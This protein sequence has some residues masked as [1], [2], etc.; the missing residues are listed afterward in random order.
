[1]EQ[2]TLEQQAQAHNN[3]YTDLE[4]LYRYATGG[5]LVTDPYASVRQEVPITLT[6]SVVIPAWNAQG[7]LAQCLIAIEQSSFNRKYPGQLE[8]VVV[9][10]GSSDG[11]WAVLEHLE[12]GLRLKAVQQSHHS[13]AHTQ[14]TGIALAAG[15]V[16]ISC[17][18]DMILTPF[19]IEELMKRHQAL[20]DV[21]LLGFRSDIQLTD[22]RI[23]PRVLESYLPQFL[24]PYAQD[25][26]LN[27]AGGWPES[28]CR[29]TDHLKRLGHGKRIIMPDGSRWDL[30]GIVYGALFSL[31]RSDFL[32]MDGYDERFYGWGCEDT[33]VGVRALAMGKYI[34]PV[35]SAAGL[36][37]AHG[38]RSRRKWQEFAANT[39]VFHMIRHTPF[40]PD[41][42]RW[43]PQASQ[44]V[45]R[46]LE[47]KPVESRRPEM[48][49]CL[50]EAFDRALAEPARRGKYLH[51]LGRYDEAAAAFSEVV[52]TEE[53]RAWAAF[54]RGK[55][56][57]S[58]GYFVEAMD[59]LDEAARRLPSNAWP[60]IESGLALAA[61]ERYAEARTSVEEARAL[62]PG[63]A[64]VKFL[65]QQPLLKRLNRADAYAQQGDHDL[66]VRDY[67]AALIL[68]P[69]GTAAAV[70]RA[71]SLAALGQ[72]PAARTILLSP[73]LG[74]SACGDNERASAAYLQLARFYLDRYEI[75]LAKV[76]LQEAWRLRPN[77]QEVKNAMNDVHA[78]AEKAYPLPVARQII[79][80]VQSIPGWLS[81]DEADLLIA[82]V[83]RAAAGSEISDS[84]TPLTLLEIGSY[85]G[86]ATVAM[87][88]TLRGLGRSEARVISI[89]EPGVG[90]AAGNRLPRDVLCVFRQEFGVEDMIVCAP[91]EI[92]RPWERAC[93]LLLVDGRH[94]YAGVREDVERYTPTL[95]D[96]GLLLFHDYAG[97]FPDVQR[98]VNELLVAGTYSFVAHAESL[99][100]LRCRHPLGIDESQGA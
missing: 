58:A 16:I 28:M 5:E 56:L 15:D 33:L 8:V 52:G 25:T 65:L 38:D 69:A 32:A 60:R 84:S 62:E 39:R 31:R 22:A 66:A 27:Y 87:A 29:D 3:D 19:S 40:I 14:N 64:W 78:L 80:A 81:D 61:L 82:L 99:I 18:A 23:H 75:G 93:R 35:Y 7:T 57:R 67:E 70:K 10:D 49:S 98:Y 85:C 34:I 41:Q 20:D 4:A 37:I 1:M 17:D 90:L 12:L 42:R 74:Y 59:A 2:H 63:N 89:D 68:E 76:A 24:P 51:G 53:Q 21:L 13:R 92:A 73:R 54:D 43:L 79:R 9:D 83:L 36:H 30:P 50:Y 11:T 96:G 44:R 94:D 45:R 91:E 95:V 46:H 55:A 6:A 86:R 71:L 88:L 47:R 100:A 26:R 72:E 97:Y 77:D 48:S